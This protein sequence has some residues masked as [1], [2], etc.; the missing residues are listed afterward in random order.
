MAVG[1]L[2]VVMAGG[3][4]SA[5][6]VDDPTQ[7]GFWYMSVTGVEQVHASGITGEGITIAVLDGPINPDLPELVGTNLVVQEDSFC[8]QDGDGVVESA[9]A[10]DGRAMHASN[11]AAVILGTGAPMNGQPGVRGVAPGATVRHYAIE[12]DWAA[13]HTLCETNGRAAVLTAVEQAMEDGA[14]IISMSFA[15]TGWGGA[16]ADAVVARAVREGVILL[17][18]SNHDGGKYVGTP[19]DFN[20]AVGIEA[21]TPA[22]TPG[23]TAVVSPELDVVAPGEGF[24]LHGFDEATGTWTEYSTLTGSSHATAFTAGVLALAWSAHPEA[25][26][27]QMIQALVRTTTQ[28]SGELR[29]ND[30]SWGYGLVNVNNLMTVDPTRYPDENPLISAEGGEI[31]DISVIFPE[32]ETEP[33]PTDDETDESSGPVTD[34]TDADDAGAG[35][36][37]MLVAGGAAAVVLVVVAAMVVVRGRRR[38][39]TVPTVPETAARE[40]RDVRIG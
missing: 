23:P 4:A 27:N 21:V 29:R 40:V 25:T 1:W 20:G 19:G 8:D 38:A 28:N 16:D 32:G 14:D 3:A 15:G 26:G 33:T 13:R 35:L 2:T 31:P 24:L 39:A 36:S 11:M 10:T 34:A 12:Y 6:T 37:P 5:T 18:A 22:G 30:D 9:L 7:G 17:G